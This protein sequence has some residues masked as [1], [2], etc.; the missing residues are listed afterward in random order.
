MKKSKFV[1][2]FFNRGHSRVVSLSKVPSKRFD[3]EICFNPGAGFGEMFYAPYDATSAFSD[4]LSLCHDLI[5][6]GYIVA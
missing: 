4:F 5:D 2:K 3:Y 6:S 1:V